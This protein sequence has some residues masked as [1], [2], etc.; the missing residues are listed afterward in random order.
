MFLHRVLETF[1]QLVR[2]V[3]NR[4]ARVALVINQ[5]ELGQILAIASS[6]RMK[7]NIA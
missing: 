6:M 1:G 5:T 3:K 7:Q 2:I 4:H